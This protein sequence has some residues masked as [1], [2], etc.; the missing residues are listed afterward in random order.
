MR[1]RFAFSKLS[2]PSP[3][4]VH[5]STVTWRNPTV[6]TAATQGLSLTIDGDSDTAITG[7]INGRDVQLTLGELREGARTIIMHG[8][9][10]PAVCFHRAAPRAAYQGDFTFEDTR[11]STTRDWYYVRVRQQNGHCAWSSPIWIDPST[12]PSLA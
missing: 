1:D 11:S 4:R 12:D 5:L 9:V 7:R 10:S 3:D 6:T 2:Q 8:F